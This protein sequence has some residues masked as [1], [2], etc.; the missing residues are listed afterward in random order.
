MASVVDSSAEVRQAAAYGVGVA[1]QYGGPSYLQACASALPNLFAMI[2]APGS[3]SHENVLATENA[4]SA[5]GKVCHFMGQSGAFDLDQI[6]S[7]WVAALPIVEDSDEAPH[8]YTYLMELLQQ[9][10]ES[11]NDVSRKVF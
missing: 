4:I 2:N 3:K 5:V 10:V 1:A 11:F 7:A 8:T 6:L 9:Y